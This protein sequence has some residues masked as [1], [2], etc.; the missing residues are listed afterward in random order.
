MLNSLLNLFFPRVC[1]AC[2]DGLQEQVEHICLKCRHSLPRTNAHRIPNNPVE[3]IFWGRVPF[4]KVTAFLYFQKTGKVQNLLH[5][6]KYKGIKEIGCTLGELAAQELQ[7]D[8]FFDDIDLILPIPLHP[9]KQK[10][11]GY[12]Q[13]HFLAKG[14]SNVTGIP[15]NSSILNKHSNTQS[16]TRK[17]RFQRWQNVESSFSVDQSESLENQHLL[18]VDD[19]VTTGATVEACASPLLSIKN[20]KL[21]LLSIAFP[22]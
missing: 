7:D 3:K 15:W 19:V 16:Q 13:S 18:L 4:Q 11:R 12:N 14:L 5:H 22:Y 2:G 1:Y 6:L 10:K 20:V 9:Q 17:N 8:N 21:S